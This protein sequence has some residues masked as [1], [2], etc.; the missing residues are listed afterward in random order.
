MNCMKNLQ[1]KK[2]RGNGMNKNDITTLLLYWILN[3]TVLLDFKEVLCH[4]T[5]IS[6]S[7][8]HDKFKCQLIK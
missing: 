2:L 3:I 5:I 7:Q 4:R 6:M 1:E 8:Y